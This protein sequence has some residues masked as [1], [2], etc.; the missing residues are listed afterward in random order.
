MN[1][2]TEKIFRCKKVLSSE[3]IEY[4]FK[5]AEGGY[6]YVEKSPEA[7]MTFT[8]KI[9]CDGN[10]EATATDNATGEPY[11]LFLAD[12]AAGEFVGKVR[13]AYESLLNGIA[14]ACCEREVFKSADAHKILEYVS[15]IY[16]SQPEYLWDKFPYNAVLRRKD[17]AKW[18]C[19]LLTVAKSKIGMAGEGTVEIIDVRMKPEE[20]ESVVD[21]AT[22]FKG[23]HMNKKHWVTIPLNG[24]TNINEI[25]KRIDESYILATK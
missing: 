3:L 2:I 7:D 23:Y 21:G 11:T 9:T 12:G 8:V 22:Y 6:V 16:G 19:V 17:N 25:F 20:A 4:G 10:I 18:F 13:T 15:R 14:S 24:G 5:Q 1:A